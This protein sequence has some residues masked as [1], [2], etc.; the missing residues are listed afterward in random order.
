[1]VHSNTGIT[2]K[3]WNPDGPKNAPDSWPAKFK[4][5]PS[6][7]HDSTR[8]PEARGTCDIPLYKLE[9]DCITGRGTWIPHHMW[10]PNE[11]PC[12]GGF[13]YDGIEQEACGCGPGTNRSCRDCPHDCRVVIGRYPFI[14][15]SSSSATTPSY[16]D[17]IFG[18]STEEYCTR[19]D[20]VY[21][22]VTGGCD[23]CG[24]CCPSMIGV[25]NIYEHESFA[26]LD[27]G[28]CYP[29]ITHKQFT[30]QTACEGS[31]INGVKGTWLSTDEDIPAPPPDPLT[32]AIPTGVCFESGPVL[33]Q[34]QVLLPGGSRKQTGATT[35]A[36]CNG[37]WVSIA[38]LNSSPPGCIPPNKCSD[39]CGGSQVGVCHEPP[40]PP[41]AE[42]PIIWG[43]S[44]GDCISPNMWSEDAC[45]T[46]PPCC[47]KRG[48]QLYAK[49]GY[50]TLKAQISG[51]SCTAGICETDL[52][53]LGG[54]GLPIS[55]SPWEKFGGIDPYKEV[56]ITGGGGGGG[57]SG[58]GSA[59]IQAPGGGF[60]QMST[61]NL[62]S[63]CGIWG[64]T[65]GTCAG[66]SSF[67]AL[68]D[69][70]CPNCG[71]MTHPKPAPGH[72]PDDVASNT[73]FTATG[74]ID[75]P[76]I[77]PGA[78]CEYTNLRLVSGKTNC[79]KCCSEDLGPPHGDCSGHCED[80]V[81]G[82][83]ITSATNGFD[84]TNSSGGVWVL[85]CEDG[86]GSGGGTGGAAP[87]E[88]DPGDPGGGGGGGNGC[89]FNCTNPPGG[90]Y[91][92]NCA[93]SKA[94]AIE[95]G[96]PLCRT[97]DT[98]CGDTICTQSAWT[99]PGTCCDWITVAGDCASQSIINRGQR[100]GK[101]KC[102]CC[103]ACPSCVSD[104]YGNLTQADMTFDRDADGTV[105]DSGD[106][107]PVEEEGSG[108]NLDTSECSR[109][110][111]CHPKIKCNGASPIGKGIGATCDCPPCPPVDPDDPCKW[112]PCN[113]GN[114]PDGA[115]L[116]NEPG[117]Y[118]PSCRCGLLVLGLVF[119]VNPFA[120][121]SIVDGEG[122]CGIFCDGSSRPYWGTE[123]CP[124]AVPDGG[125]SGPGDPDDP[126]GGDD[127]GDP[128]DPGD[129]GD[130]GVGG[131][132]GSSG[133]GGGVKKCVG[134]GEIYPRII[135]D[136][137]IDNICGCA[138]S[139]W[140]G[141]CDDMCAP[142]TGGIQTIYLICNQESSCKEDCDSLGISREW[143]GE[144]NKDRCGAK[145]G[146]ELCLGEGSTY[147][148]ADPPHAGNDGKFRWGDTGPDAPTWG[149]ESECPCGA[150]NPMDLNCCSGLTRGQVECMGETGKC[151]GGPHLEG[152]APGGTLCQNHWRGTDRYACGHEWFTPPW[153]W[154]PVCGGGCGTHDEK[155]TESSEAGVCQWPGPLGGG[156]A[157][158]LRTGNP[159]L[160][161]DNMI[162][163]SS[164]FGT[165]KGCVGDPETDGR[166]SC[167]PGNWGSYSTKTACMKDDKDW[168]TNTWV[169]TNGVC[170]HRSGH[171]VFTDAGGVDL[172][173][174]EVTCLAMGS[175]TDAGC[176]GA[177]CDLPVC[178]DKWSTLWRLQ[179]D[180]YWHD[181]T[182]AKDNQELGSPSNQYP[183]RV[184]LL[185]YEYGGLGDS[186]YDGCMCGSAEPTCTA[187]GGCP[188]MPNCLGA[189][190]SCE[191]NEWEITEAECRKKV[192][193]CVGTTTGGGTT[194]GG[195][196]NGG[197]GGGYDPGAGGTGGTG[198]S[199][200]GGGGDADST[201]YDWKPNPF[202]PQ[203]CFVPDEICKGCLTCDGNN[204]D[205]CGG[206]GGKACADKDRSLQKSHC[207]S[208]QWCDEFP[209]VGKC[210]EDC[211]KLSLGCTG[212]GCGNYNPHNWK[213]RRCGK[214][215][216][217]FHVLFNGTTYKAGYEDGAIKHLSKPNCRLF[218]PDSCC[219]DTIYLEGEE[220]PAPFIRI[221][222]IDVED[223]GEGYTI[224]PTVT[225][226][227]PTFVALPDGIKARA[228]S[229]IDKDEQGFD[230]GKLD[231]ISITN[232][233]LGYAD[234]D[235]PVP[236]PITISATLSNGCAHIVNG[237]P[238]QEHC[239]VCV[240][241]EHKTKTECSNNIGKCTDV[242]G[243][244]VHEHR[245]LAACENADDTNS[246][247][248]SVG[249]WTPMRQGSLS[250]RLEAWTGDCERGTIVN[251]DQIF[252][253]NAACG[254]IA[255]N[256]CIP[257][258]SPDAS[259]SHTYEDYICDDIIMTSWEKLGPKVK[260][261][262][263]VNIWR[264]TN[265]KKLTKDPEEL[266][267]FMSMASSINGDYEI[268]RI[269][270]HD[271][272]IKLL[273]S[274]RQVSAFQPECQAG[275]CKDCQQTRVGVTDE[276]C[277]KTGKYGTH[278]AVCVKERFLD[279]HGNLA[280]GCEGEWVDGDCGKV[281]P[282]CPSCD[283]RGKCL[284]NGKCKDTN[285]DRNIHNG[286]CRGKEEYDAKNCTD[287][288]KSLEQNI[289]ECKE[290]C[291]GD[292]NNNCWEG[293]EGCL[294][295][296][297]G[298]YDCQ[299]TAV[300]LKCP[301]CCW[302][303]D[304]GGKLKRCNGG[305]PDQTYR[306][307]GDCDAAL[308]A[309]SW[310]EGIQCPDGCPQRKEDCCDSGCN[311]DRILKDLDVGAMSFP[312]HPHTG[313]SIC[314]N[315]NHSD[316]GGIDNL[317]NR[318]NISCEP[319]SAV[320]NGEWD[321]VAGV[322][323]NIPTDK[324][325][326]GSYD[327]L[328]GGQKTEWESGCC[329]E[330]AC[331]VDTCGEIEPNRG[332]CCGLWSTS[333]CACPAN[334]KDCDGNII[335]VGGTGADKDDPIRRPFIL[336]LA[337]DGGAGGCCATT[338]TIVGLS[339]GNLSS[340]PQMQSRVTITEA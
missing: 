45:H 24:P 161:Q 305:C 164:P 222:Q 81:N 182:F 233:G 333:A 130:G 265:P 42:G 270:A 85:D 54:A 78:L 144:C 318:G 176:Q 35:E 136:C 267:A 95:A 18:C 55:I 183:K 244:E 67:V 297:C 328:T 93:D 296:C 269:S 115:R 314:A 226:D 153:G 224:A 12:C 239:G 332:D 82:G 212:G 165:A 268:E 39:N 241:K 279:S 173:T 227:D 63:T 58:L 150:D 8:P 163:L 319:C 99:S 308:G 196:S 175:C 283:A 199:G 217:Q 304:A 243:D 44:K 336:D 195:G 36:A 112:Y 299:Q 198:G 30:D 128:G 289:E 266:G 140:T 143:R 151:G 2:E 162:Q 61:I 236:D 141:R 235:A 263:R 17:P 114:S 170:W 166:C 127:T 125:A 68:Y 211:K 110:A 134:C 157:H 221:A 248:P 317:P 28:R 288:N 203:G 4:Y 139:D 273:C 225:I 37:V 291:L 178:A 113:A 238:N 213:H 187:G 231:K 174:D 321:E 320:L 194:G 177:D 292:S 325:R 149:D 276:D 106:W 160:Q 15:G 52:T 275:Y 71:Y 307:K 19:A 228:I 324:F 41:L 169:N 180:P 272:D 129:P 186:C 32:G 310:K 107:C 47:N 309:G 313:Y 38:R 215:C 6:P 56:L 156:G 119:H 138:E 223:Y 66:C 46:Q 154:P 197:T 264:A 97:V 301:S 94:N 322:C 34:G 167:E 84:C 201:G 111:L 126:A 92:C 209:K 86:G 219:P 284:Y 338:S 240:A 135:A 70:N 98:H 65:F 3:N 205:V 131:G 207:L 90:F 147:W 300:G 91:Q 259:K 16:L 311:K 229:Y 192:K 80:S 142:S 287:P 249:T 9:S 50:E 184:Q 11:P 10:N 294:E 179:N 218:A 214:T 22:W 23:C 306:T 43:T 260:N 74:C 89:G 298:C 158:C 262:N 253:N 137:H 64:G 171:R 73:P 329:E 258:N 116:I 146:G 335:R 277:C 326:C 100:C 185:D 337:I 79:T 285:G 103:E 76:A 312:L 208:K 257:G 62:E 152:V 121:K 108:C 190:F 168:I 5:P 252:K 254:C 29:I 123:V 232:K 290:G 339:G 87:G 109:E 155:L 210:S 101:G 202:A 21:P 60:Y 20:D 280:G 14:D 295:E 26:T 331:E 120:P 53:W 102:D 181:T 242:N 132:G 72:D 25:N 133:G 122:N 334:F 216:N 234:P 281:L 27:T 51:C 206:C 13:N 245:N 200:S 40:R 148:P 104:R 286:K 77:Q 274:G 278:E 261:G 255:F 246:W 247:T 237:V 172:I 256:D 340:F 33:D 302:D 1:M 250:L 230:Y 303:V 316:F 193:D 117:N 48:A 145:R 323:R 189:C 59:G 88:G 282:N 118:P 83:V 7:C 293:A 49:E 220:R 124:T 57:A 75:F 191:G 188:D 251:K 315:P 271:Y 159:P 96:I 327:H 330:K 204:A 69:V 31:S 105:I